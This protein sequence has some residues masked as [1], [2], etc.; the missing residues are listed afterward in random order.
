MLKIH[1]VSF[2]YDRR[3]LDAISFHAPEG[4]LTAIVG[5]NGSGKTTL[6]RIARGLLRPA[7]G[8]VLL[9]GKSLESYSRRELAQTVGY[10]M[11]DHSLGFPLSVLEYVLHGRF[12]YSNGFGFE[13]ERDVEIALEALTLTGTL[14]FKDKLVNALSGGERQRVVLARAIA[15]EPRALL[16]DEPTANL[17]IRYQVEMLSLVKRLT[18]ERPLCS[19]F[20]AHELNLASEFADQVLLLKDGHAVAVGSPEQVLTEENLTTVFESEF[21]VDCNPI[22]GLPRI[23]I[24]GGRRGDDSQFQIE[25]R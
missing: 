16:L 5:P 20:I 19:I 1:N 23:T 12:P 25:A 10:V 18:M 7:S 17:D 3:V 4:K 15:G 8:E 2:A 24:S 13:R 14:E 22:S 6:L 11:Q 21:Q 9:N